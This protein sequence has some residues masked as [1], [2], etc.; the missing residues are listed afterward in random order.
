MKCFSI[1]LLFICLT[2]NTQAQDSAY[3]RLFSLTQELSVG[4]SLHLE[5]LNEG[6]R[7][8]TS[9]AKKFFSPI[10]SSG[11]NRFKNRF[12]TCLGRITDHENFDLFLV[13]EDRRRADSSSMATTYLVSL[14]KSGDHIASQKVLVTGTKKRSGYNIQSTLYKDNRIFIDTKII[15]GE[16]I[17]EE[18]ENYRIT[19]NGRFILA[20]KDN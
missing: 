18:V 10:L 11:N 6:V 20:E 13:L 15:T 3:Q 9:L 14:K 2:K 17:F 7:L 16:R 4:D 19:K 8:D 5:E 12:Y 1:I